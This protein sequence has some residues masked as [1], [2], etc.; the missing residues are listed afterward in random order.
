MVD[1]DAE[2]GQLKLLHHPAMKACRHVMIRQ[3]N[4]GANELR[5]AN[6]GVQNWWCSTV[7]K[8]HVQSARSIPPSTLCWTRC[9]TTQLTPE[10]IRG[11]KGWI[12][13]QNTCFKVRVYTQCI[14]I[15]LHARS[16]S[17]LHKAHCN[18]IWY[19]PCIEMC[20]MHDK[21]NIIN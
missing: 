6:G 18:I 10:A 7:T 13:T 16:M 3:E 14:Y 15:F 20:V 8:K 4:T 5:W 2:N 1:R 17:I 9:E 11:C 21:I 19:K 12:P